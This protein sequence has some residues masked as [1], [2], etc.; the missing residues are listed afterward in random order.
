MYI[1]IMY[2]NL[3]CYIIVTHKIE[4]HYTHMSQI[5][6]YTS[7]VCTVSR[8]GLDLEVLPDQGGVRIEAHA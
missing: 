8:F 5:C 3:M 6:V 2:V 4:S 7:T 1:V